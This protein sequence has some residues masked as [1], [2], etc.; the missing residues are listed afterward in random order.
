[1][2]QFDLDVYDRFMELFDNLPIA[3]TVNGRYISIHGG[4]AQGL[5]TFQ[6]INHVNRVCEPE[7]DTLLSDLLWADPVPERHAQA[8]GYVANDERGTSVKFG[9]KPLQK[10]LKQENLDALIRAH[11]VKQT[12]YEF[13][14]ND[15]QGNP[16]CI[17]IFSA[18]NY[19]GRW[20][21]DGAVFFTNQHNS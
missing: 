19:G 11:Q 4:I 14:C 8:V 16:N 7:S 18:P 2:Q 3:A 21:N 12:G 10:L 1:M 20:R 6:Q 9:L 13:Q 5:N 17:T 15:R